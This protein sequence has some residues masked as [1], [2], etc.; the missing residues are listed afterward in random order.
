MKKLIL[1]MMIVL[2]AGMVTANRYEIFTLPVCYG[3]TQ[4][5]VNAEK[6]LPYTIQSDN[7]WIGLTIWNKT[8]DNLWSFPSIY[9]DGTINMTIYL[10]TT[11]KTAN[12]YDFRIQYYVEPYI[13]VTNKSGNVTITYEEIENDSNK[14]VV[15]INDFEIGPEPYKWRLPTRDDLTLIGIIIG[16]IIIGGF[17]VVLF[18]VWKLTREKT[19]KTDIFGYKEN[20]H[21]PKADD[22]LTD[23]QLDEFLKNL[24]GK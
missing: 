8:D 3:E 13:I 18:V 5:M 11:N 6:D 10:E 1:L 9:C 24:G 19:E 2:M 22:D 21:E 23:E 16:A 14:R 12:T 7:H 20:S 15:N 4:I 17:I